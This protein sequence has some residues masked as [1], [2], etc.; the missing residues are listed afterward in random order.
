MIVRLASPIDIEG[1][2]RTALVDGVIPV[3][4]ETSGC[5]RAV[6]RA[7]RDGVDVTCGALGG[8]G[9]WSGEDMESSDGE[10]VGWGPNKN[11]PG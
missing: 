1:E 6:V 11:A 3:V 7:G 4:C 9:L 8:V 5:G 10:G 2:T